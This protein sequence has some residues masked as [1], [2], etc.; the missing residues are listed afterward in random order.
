MFKFGI[1]LILMIAGR[2]MLFAES[3]LAS[4]AIPLSAD[5]SAIGRACMASFHNEGPITPACS[6]FARRSLTGLNDDE[7]GFLIARLERSY[8]DIGAPA[9]D[10]VPARVS[11]DRVSQR[12]TSAT[13]ECERGKTGLL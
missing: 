7:R 9:R 4:T 12:M 1:P 5:E 13:D 2:F 10:W 3:P 6:C 8:G 11:S